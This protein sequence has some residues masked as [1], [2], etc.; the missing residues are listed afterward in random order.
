MLS[1]DGW[2][3][4]R[5]CGT[6]MQYRLFYGACCIINTPTD[7]TWIW[8]DNSIRGKR[9]RKSG[10]N[11]FFMTC[12]APQPKFQTWCFSSR[13]EEQGKI[14][15]WLH[16]DKLGILNATALLHTWPHFCSEIWRWTSWNAFIAPRPQ[17]LMSY[18]TPAAADFNGSEGW[19]ALRAAVPICV[20]V[21]PLW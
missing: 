3:I 20:A 18:D 17:C 14:M 1:N 5:N 19:M 6:E 10:G 12:S 4:P 7:M 16:G 13:D 11:A 15:T 9:V 2:V 8:Y 21:F